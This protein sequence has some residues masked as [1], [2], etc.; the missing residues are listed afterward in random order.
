MRT[1][2]PTEAQ[3][4]TAVI[5]LAQ[6]SGWMVHHVGKAQL[7]GRWVTP[8]VADGAGFPDLVLVA[9]RRD[10]PPPRLLFVELKTDRGRLSAAQQTW[11]QVL[12]EAKAGHHHWTWDVWRPRDWD[13]IRTRLTA[14]HPAGGQP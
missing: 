3:F 10:I 11:G 2:A 5:E 12:L 9:K 8:T 13:R 6:L 1:Q 14:R 7:A 4:Q